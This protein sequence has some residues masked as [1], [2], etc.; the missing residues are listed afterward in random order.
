MLTPVVCSFHA[1]QRRVKQLKG[2]KGVSAFENLVIGA[3]AAT[4]VSGE[5]RV[6]V[7]KSV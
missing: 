7:Q 2:G 3:C 1:A 6:K 5:E 4:V